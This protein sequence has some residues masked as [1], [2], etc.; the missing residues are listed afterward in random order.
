[1]IFVGGG[2]LGVFAFGEAY[3]LYSEFFDSTSLGPIR[4]FDSLG[5]SQSL[6][7]FL[8]IAVAVGAFA[9]TTLIERRVNPAEAPSLTFPKRNHWIAAGGVLLAGIVLLIVPNRKEHLIRKVSDPAYAAAHPI[10]RMTADEL[11]F[12]II[13][14]EPTIRLIDVRPAASFASFALPGSVNLQLQDMLTKDG[15]SALAQ[16]YVKKVIVGD[17]EDD[18]RIAGS[19]MHELGYENYAILE[20]G[21]D[22]FRRTI[23]APG[24]VVLT[25]SRWDAD[26]NRFRQEA[27]V[28]IPKMIEEQ[29]HAMTK[30]PKPVKKI[31]GGC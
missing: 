23:L 2:V 25:G 6:F 26:V 15:V 3:P 5:M 18:E 7:A 29:K 10:R 31:Q 28:T 9:L 27:K 8:L 17:A 20:G 21:M 22:S 14:R 4:V 1:M 30:R 13:D 19:L 11:A 12:R 24:E 16:R